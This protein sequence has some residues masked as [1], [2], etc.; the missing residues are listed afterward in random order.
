[1]LDFNATQAALRAGYSEKTAR[2][3][4]QRLL[5]KVDIS[6][7]I[8]ARIDEKAMKADE[9][10]LRLADMARGDIGDFMNISPMSYSLD[11]EK[12]KK[13]GLTHLIKKVK[14]R[15]V[16]TVNKD[17]EESETQYIEIELHDPQAALVQLGRHHALFIDKKEISGLT[18]NVKVTNDNN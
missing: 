15:S 2:S 12:A 5:T 10:L 16:M 13:A 7:A 3:Q 11:L 18:I 1:M 4:G 17:G 6:K 8:Q 9:V 14:D